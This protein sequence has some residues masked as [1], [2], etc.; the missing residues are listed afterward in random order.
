MI[1]LKWIKRCLVFLI[2]GVL[3][4]VLGRWGFSSSFKRLPI[5]EASM[6][7]RV[8][9]LSKPIYDGKLSGTK[10]NTLSTEYIAAQ[11]KELGI[12][13][14]GKNETYFQSFSLMVPIIDTEPEFIL[15]NQKMEKIKSFVMYEDYVALPGYNGGKIDYQGELLLVGTNLLRIDPTIIKDRI[16]VIDADRINIDRIQYVLDH[17]GKGLLISAD[18]KTYGQAQ[19]LE[20]QKNLSIQGKTGKSIFVGYISHDLNL[21]LIEQSKLEENTYDSVLGV[22]KNCSIKVTIDYPIMDSKNVFAVIPGNSKSDRILMLS[23]NIDGLGKSIKDGYFQSA[24]QSS[25]GISVLLELGR[26]LKEQNIQGYKT[27]VLVGWNGSKEDEAGVAY[28]VNHPLYPLDK[29]TVIHIDRV[30]LITRD[31]IGLVSENMISAILKDKVLNY[32][33]DK[34]LNV[35]K[36]GGDHSVIKQ[37]V[38]KGVPA[39]LVFDGS[40]PGSGTLD[41]SEAI[42]PEAL[43]NTAS[44]LL[45]YLEKEVYHTFEYDYLTTFEKSLILTL[46]CLILMNILIEYV[47]KNY[48]GKK[49][50]GLSIE[51]L[52]FKLP[53]LI[54]RKYFIYLLSFLAVIFLLA[55]LVHLNGAMNIMNINGEWTTNF[56]LYLAVKKTLLY[57]RSI[58]DISNYKMYTDIS[59]LKVIASSSMLSIKL[60]GGALLLS[61]I[62]GV[63]SGMVESFAAKKNHLSS[64]GMI[65]FFSIP[66]VLIVLLGVLSYTWI[67]I[68]LPNIKNLL[69]LKEYILPLISLSII[70]TVYISRM[71]YVTVMEEL[72]K[73]YVKAAKALGYSKFHIYQKDILPAV[74]FKTIDSLPTIMTMLLSNMIIIEYLFNYNGIVYYLLY[75]YKSHDL[76]RFVPMALTL[77]LIYIIFVVGIKMIG[78]IINPLRKEV[79]NR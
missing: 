42:Q 40:P 46:L 12:L 54:F 6:Y 74:L 70:P 26:I 65:V 35:T 3:L 7:N 14:G 51:S 44:L 77:A 48:Q 8:Q 34:G 75:L 32:G 22:I 49:I 79:K 4:F 31:G 5:D 55:F 60:I 78:K 16:I 59:T 43:K 18:S 38:N 36:S 72:S 19:L 62:I 13:P 25:S 69:P 68:H 67:A 52:Y 30:G 37:F 29:T 73:D 64:I 45:S 27:V 28:Y 71:T 76:Y 23:A 21:S 56:S 61:F 24:N 66:D 33:L 50:G 58:F 57:L 17:G 41:Y 15:F 2:L 53:I 1:A 9:E 10:G 39:L 11:F 47:Y 20:Q 63:F